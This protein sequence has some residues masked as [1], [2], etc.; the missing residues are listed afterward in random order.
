MPL[1]VVA[2]LP[3]KDK[4][5]KKLVKASNKPKHDNKGLIERDKAI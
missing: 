2:R 4:I 3:Q 5:A 1:G